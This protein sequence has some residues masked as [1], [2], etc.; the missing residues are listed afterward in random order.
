MRRYPG[1]PSA[2]WLPSPGQRPHTASV[3]SVAPMCMDA[4][5]AHIIGE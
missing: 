5:E 1:D 3:Q 2:P 4:A